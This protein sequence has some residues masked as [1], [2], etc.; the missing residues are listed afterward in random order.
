MQTKKLG[1]GIALVAVAAVVA[2]FVVLRDDD[3]P[4]PAPAP[5]TE[6]PAP[7]PGEP[8]E[9]AESAEPEIPEVVVRD[10]QPVGGVA[11]LEFSRGDR[12]RFAVRSDAGDELHVHGYDIYE[13]IEAGESTR[14]EFRADFDGVFEVELHDAHVDIARITIR[15]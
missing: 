15:P 13:D 6:E 11:E 8:D 7:A 2:L 4:E 3:E 1:A 14:V 5:A 9:P 12:V 10:G